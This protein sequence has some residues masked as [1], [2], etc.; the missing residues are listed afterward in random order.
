MRPTIPETL[1]TQNHDIRKDTYLGY[2]SPVRRGILVSGDENS[3]GKGDVR[4]P[5]LLTRAN[6]GCA[7]VQ[8]TRGRARSGLHTVERCASAARVP[9]VRHMW[10]ARVLRHVRRARAIKDT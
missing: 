5:G 3:F 10:G 2:Y 9:P 6:P 4:T 7:G 8:G 1:V